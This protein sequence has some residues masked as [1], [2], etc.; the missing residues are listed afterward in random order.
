MF[1]RRRRAATRI[2]GDSRIPDGDVVCRPGQPPWS[3]M[4]TEELP[5]VKPGTDTSALVRGYVAH[6]YVGRHCERS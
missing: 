5:I 1:W 6:G 4:L 3:D 2:E